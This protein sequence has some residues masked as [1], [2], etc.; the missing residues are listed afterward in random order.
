ME[1]VVTL[2]PSFGGLY[3]LA[4]LWR[5]Q[6]FVPIKIIDHQGGAGVSSTMMMTFITRGGEGREDKD[7]DRKA[8]KSEG[9]CP[10]EGASRALRSLG[11]ETLENVFF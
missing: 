4:S 2:S 9:R 1:F 5:L 10:E 6:N 11:V 7:K 8:T 3:P